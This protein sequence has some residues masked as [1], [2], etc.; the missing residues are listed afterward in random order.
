M[1][2]PGFGKHV[3]DAARWIPFGVLE[4]AAPR[5][6]LRSHHMAQLHRGCPRKNEYAVGM[7]L[8][9]D[10]SSRW[11]YPQGMQA[12]LVPYRSLANFFFVSFILCYSGRRSQK[13]SQ[14]EIFGF[15][16]L[17]ER[18]KEIQATGGKPRRSRGAARSSR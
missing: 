12:S 10:V 18:M 9:R 4:A 15:D 13:Q 11:R 2:L 8:S 14:S 16:G 7:H 5:L 3:L 1:H 17:E 6:P